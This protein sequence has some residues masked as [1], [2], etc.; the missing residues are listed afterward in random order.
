MSERKLG[1]VSSSSRRK[2]PRVGG[3]RNNPEKVIA[4][5]N[6]AIARLEAQLEILQSR[7]RDGWLNDQVE[8]KMRHLEKTRK[9]AQ[10]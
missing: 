8:A 10:Q 9:N 7:S 1:R 3:R 6:S 4:R 2:Y 5:R